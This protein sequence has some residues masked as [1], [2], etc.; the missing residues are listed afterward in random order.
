MRRNIDN[1]VKGRGRKCI[2]LYQGIVARRAGCFLVHFLDQAVK[3]FE[4][5]RVW[6]S[7]VERIQPLAH[8]LL[9]F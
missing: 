3:L 2:V 4:A 5:L 1:S 8:V 6:I 7:R 9:A